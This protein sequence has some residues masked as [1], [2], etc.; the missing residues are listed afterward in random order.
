MLAGVSATL[1]GFA[2]TA[3]SRAA[4]KTVLLAAGGA[5]G[6]VGVAAERAAVATPTQSALGLAV[7][8]VGAV[9]GWALGIGVASYRANRDIQERW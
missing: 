4:L 9:L 5:G 2:A 1:I 3:S 8:V 6:S 7:F